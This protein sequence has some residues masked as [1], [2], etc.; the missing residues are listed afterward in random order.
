MNITP[1]DTKVA[2][3]VPGTSNVTEPNPEL[4]RQW[5]NRVIERLSRLFGGATALPGIGGYVS[6]TAGLITENVWVVHAFT[7]AA[8]LKK[9]RPEVLALANELCAAMDQEC[10]AVEFNGKLF[11]AN[12]ENAAELAAA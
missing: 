9:N 7:D 3:T 1:L 6:D 4:Q 5:V 8:G 2:I 10:V 11:F 12:Q